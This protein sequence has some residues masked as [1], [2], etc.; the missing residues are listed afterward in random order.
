MSGVADH[1]HLQARLGMAFG[2]DV[3]LADQRAGGIDINHLPVL[4]GG[5]DRLGDAMGRED[6]GPVVGAFVQLFDKNSALV[7]QAIDD[8][9]VVHDFVAH[10]DR[11]APFF[12]RHF[13]DL[14]GTVDTCTKPARGGKEQGQG[15]FGRH[16][17][18][19]HGDIRQVGCRAGR[20]NPIA[21]S[22][23]PLIT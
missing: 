16:I 5:R 19:R 17:R 2:F 10:I 18:L 20:V 22:K 8:K 3:D 15:R 21:V 11:R 1:D 6:D 9:A 7:A 13:H 23:N 12:E 4:G 14:D